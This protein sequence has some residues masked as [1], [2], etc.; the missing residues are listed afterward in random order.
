MTDPSPSAPGADAPR[1]DVAVP[2]DPHVSGALNLRDVGVNVDLAPEDAD[3]AAGTA[4]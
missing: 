3:A 4:W 2:A 1:D